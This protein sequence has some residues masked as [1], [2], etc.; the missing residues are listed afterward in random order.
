MTE[1]RELF[2]AHEG[3]APVP[4]ER[5]TLSPFGI[6]VLWGDLGVG[7][8]V[9]AAG[10]LLV[11]PFGLGLPVA[12]LATVVGSVIGAALLA[13][14]GRIGTDTGVP[15]MVAL[16]PALG[17]RGSYVASMLNILQLVG[18]AGLEFIVMA[19][20][21]RA[22]SEH[23][24]GFDGYHLWL[25][26]FAV[27]ATV[28]AVGGPV[29]VV[30]DF[31]QRFGFWIVLAATAW[32]FF[33]LFV[34]YDIHRSLDD[35]NG[36]PR[37]FWLGVDLAVALPASWLPLVADYNRFALRA[38][39]AAASTFVAY[40]LAN[41][42]FFALGIGFAIV[43]TYDTSNPNN[44]ILALVDSMLPLAVGWLFLFVILVDETDNAFANVYSTGVSIQN[45]VPVSRTVLAV[46]VGAAAFVLALSIDLL[47]YETFLLL[48]GGVFVS[49]FGVMF[50]DYFL[51][52]R[53][54][55]ETNDLYAPGGRY[56]FWNGVN[57][58]GMAAWAGGFL[59]F[60]ATGQPLWVQEHFPSVADVP[61]N[62]SDWTGL[63]ITAVGG[64]IPSFAVSVALYLLLERML[65]RRVAA[66]GSPATVEN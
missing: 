57:P 52:R 47:G 3:I 51:V 36:S 13:A 42:A 53:G 34:T 62:I 11:N 64:T 65:R 17:I 29:V 12:L 22:I 20:A 6:G 45:L 26:A 49:L 25:A 59:T 19:Q 5:R 10:G 1:T 46:A 7:L 27:L 39:G 41:I 56:W 4:A 30:R 35:W 16:R 63:D 14:I 23:F 43:L 38:G 31:L 58:A 66:V 33:R 2:G 37:A 54:R 50:A 44:L 9:L 15:T 48:I 32:L 40:A 21:A 18:W 24:F 55:Y 8:L 61:P 60:I 28:F